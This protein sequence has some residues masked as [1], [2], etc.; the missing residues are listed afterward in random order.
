MRTQITSVGRKAQQ[1]AKA[2]AAV[3]VITQEDIRRSGATNIPDLLRMVPGLVVARINGSTWTVSARGDARQ[4][5][6]KMLVMIDGR[7]IYGRLFSGVFWNSQDVFLDDVDRIEVIRGPGAVMWGSNAVNGVI[8][9][10]TKRSQSTQGGLVSLG[11]GTDDRGIAGFRYGGRLGDRL[12]YRIWGKFNA[13]AFRDAETAIY[14]RD[15]NYTTSDRRLLR[16]FRGSADP[17]GGD[18]GRLWRVGFRFDWE[19]SSRD[20]IVAI[21]E[22]HGERYSQYTWSLAPGGRLDRQWGQDRPGG[23]NVLARWTRT[24]SAGEETTLQFW[25]DSSTQ[26][27]SLYEVRVNAMDAEAQH[28]RQLS[29]NNELHLGGGF[30]ATR[31]SIRNSPFH[32]LPTLHTDHL[33][34]GVV[35]DEHQL[36][37]HKLT[38]SAGLRT[39]HNDYTGFEFQPSVRMLFTPSKTQSWWVAWSRAVRTPSRVEQDID[40]L[41]IGSAEWQ[42]MPVLLQVRG[43]ADFR[44]E[45]LRA[46]EAGYRYQRRQQWSIDVALFSNRYTRL[47]SLEAGEFHAQFFPV[48]DLRQDFRFGN[49]RYGNSRGAEVSLSSAIRPWWH[50]H[51]SYSYLRSRTAVLPGRED[52]DGPQYAADP[53]HQASVRSYWN[54]GRRWQAD[55]MLYGV[56]RVAQR[57][58]PGYLRADARLSWRPNREQE[59]SIVAQDLGSHGRLEWE[60]ELFVYAIPTRRAVVLRWVLQF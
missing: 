45:R 37:A 32:F 18:D 52:L 38:L 21:G 35:R 4:Y 54:L 40:A 58:V 28:R 25:A 14:R 34:N 15:V 9:I 55:V 7:S 16:E 50:V 10:I 13:R 47:S 44:S 17:A 27:G 36:I 56:G 8:H 57:Q 53:S 43:T 59:W 26:R 42:G 48:V 23:G 33:W 20:A 41:P 22:L 46:T 49:G 30:R 6:N 19:R 2:P 31:D 11:T 29:E 24:A 12:A 39:E 51:G 60:P 1:V 3:Y 5:A